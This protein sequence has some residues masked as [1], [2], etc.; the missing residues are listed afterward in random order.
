MLQ[1]PRKSY[2]TYESM[3]KS[4]ISWSLIKQ[5]RLV[6]RIFYGQK[7]RNYYTCYHIL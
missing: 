1:Y 6:L 5:A 3:R 7:A 2:P 4:M